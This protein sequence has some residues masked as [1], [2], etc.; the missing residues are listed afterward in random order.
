MTDSTAGYLVTHPL[1]MSGIGSNLA[2]LAG[3][4]WYAR[5]MNRELIVDWRGVAALKNK[6]LNYFTEFFEAPDYIQGIRVRYAPCPEMPQS[7]EQYPELGITEAVQTLRNGDSRSHLVLSAYHGLE[8]LDRAGSAAA[9]FWRLQEFYTSIRPRDFVRLEVDRFF[10]AHLKGGFV[11]ALNLAGGNGEFAK[12][13]P[14]AGRVDTGI[15]SNPDEFLGK[16]RWAYRLALRGLPRYLRSSGRLF[17]ATDSQAMHDLLK[18]LPNAITRR[19]TFPPP[20]VGRYFSDYND[21]GYTDRDAIVDSLVDMF[22]LARCQALVRNGT[23][24]NLYA[25]TVTNLFN[26]NCRH[27]ES[28]YL[29][30]W[31]RVAGTIARRY[32]KR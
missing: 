28:L 16:V 31:F 21:P 3:A 7:I 23:A 8:R 13:Q 6:S 10:D 20:G 27:M 2:S 29:R 25:Q 26:G 32:V 15:F 19:T 11:V 4:V 18:R 1:P 5:Q 9:Q 12:G 22:L 17:F 30:H 14:Y 24:F